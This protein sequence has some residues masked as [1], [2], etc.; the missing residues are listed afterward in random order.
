MKMQEADA[1]LKALT[2]GKPPKQLKPKAAKREN[3]Q[4]S[5][6]PLE[7]APEFLDFFKEAAGVLEDYSNILKIIS[8]LYKPA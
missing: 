2:I 7:V 4:N 8:A 3:P 6:A 1:Y 5:K